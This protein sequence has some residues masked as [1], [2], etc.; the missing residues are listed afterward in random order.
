MTLI[1][2]LA[3]DAGIAAAFGRLLQEPALAKIPLTDWEFEMVCNAPL[4]FERY[5]AYTWK[6][7]RALR[8]IAKKIA[9]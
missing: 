9:G 4:V 8:E 1:H 2:E 7:R 6:Q 5:G 3:T